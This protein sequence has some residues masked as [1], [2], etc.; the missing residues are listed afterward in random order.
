MGTLLFSV[1]CSLPI[2][3]ALVIC[4]SFPSGCC[5]TDKKCEDG[6]TCRECPSLINAFRNGDKTRSDVQ[7]KKCG[8]SRNL[9]C[10]PEEPSLTETPSLGQTEELPAEKVISVGDIVLP[11]AIPSGKI[12]S[13]SELARSVSGGCLGYNILNEPDRSVTYGIDDDYRCDKTGN[14]RVSPRWKGSGWYRFLPPAGTLLAQASPGS[15]HCNTAAP[16]WTNGTLPTV[17]GSTLDI[18]VCFDNNS[19]QCNWHKDARVT[20]CGAYY[21]YYL[22]KTP[23]CSFRYCGAN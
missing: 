2:W 1:L 21:V 16:G 23:G 10:C 6:E 7:S 5:K 22:N 13:A 11:V 20:N 19:R 18:Q 3:K 17:Q 12:F 15:S 8:D 9:F 4:L 14:G